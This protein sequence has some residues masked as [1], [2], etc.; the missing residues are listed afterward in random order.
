MSGAPCRRG[1]RT[2]PATAIRYRSIRVFSNGDWRRQMPVGDSSAAPLLSYWLKV[3]VGRERGW[4][5][6]V[7]E[8][9]GEAKDIPETY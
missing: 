5:L 7:L 2:R 8:C 4:R 3:S 6:G 1:G 9:V